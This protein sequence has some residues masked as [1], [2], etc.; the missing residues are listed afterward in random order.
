[1][2]FWGCKVC[3]K[4]LFSFC[5]EW[6]SSSPVLYPNFPKVLMQQIS[7]LVLRTGWCQHRS[8]QNLWINVQRY[9]LCLIQTLLFCAV[10]GRCHLFRGEH[11]T[12]VQEP[13]SSCFSWKK[14][15]DIT[16]QQQP[17]PAALPVL[18]HAAIWQSYFFPG[19]PSLTHTVVFTDST[20][21]DLQ[22]PD[23]R[24]ITDAHFGLNMNIK[25]QGKKHIT[26]SNMLDRA[27]WS[28]CILSI[29]WSHWWMRTIISLEICKST[30]IALLII[31][32]NG[33][34]YST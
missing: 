11:N 3:L 32:D 12:H 14:W 13:K 27:P 21:S 4:I 33:F 22:N 17:T 18:P 19:W 16:S 5:S 34:G 9:R 6:W 2:Q 24:V 26:E 29:I 15:S 20:E 1:M 28:K 30:V 10:D 25:K 31:G 23:A 8:R 7:Y